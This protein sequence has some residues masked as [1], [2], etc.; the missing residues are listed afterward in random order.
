[1]IVFAVLASVI[2]GGV[3]G[4]V[5][6]LLSGVALAL[7]R[8]RL[9]GRD[10]AARRLAFATSAGPF[11]GLA[12]CWGDARTALLVLA[13]VS[14]AAGAALAPLCVNGCPARA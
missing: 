5:V 8:E 2:V 3:I 4:A 9:L 1:V 12:V 14:G 10:A 6:G 7:A 11:L 13:V